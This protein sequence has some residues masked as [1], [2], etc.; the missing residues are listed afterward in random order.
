MACRPTL[1]HPIA[2]AV[3]L[4]LHGAA[5]AQ[6]VVTITGRSE[7]VADVS[8][9]GEKIS[10][11]PLQASVLDAASLRD[12]GI[13]SLAGITQADASVTDAYNAAGYWSLL[14]VRGF[15][16]D[17]RANYRRDGLPINAETALSLVN[18]ERVE[19]FKGT[20][21][22]QAGTSAPGGLVNLVVKRPLADRREVAL[23][24]T[25][26]GS[27]D[28]TLDLSQRLGTERR[29]GVRVNAEVATL[30]PAIRQAD[31]ER[32]LLAVAADWLVTPDA[33]LE[34]EI[35][36][37]HQ[38]QP[39]VPGFSLLGNR[40]PDARTIDPRTNLNN[41]PWSLPVVLDGDTASLRWQQRLSDDWSL[42]VHGASQRLRSDDRVAFPFGCSN[43]A[44]YLGDRYCADGSYDLYD[45]RSEGERRRTDALDLQVQGRAR[46]GSVQH[47]LTAGALLSRVHDRYQRVAN[48]YVGSGTINAD[49][50]TAADPSLTD[51]NT[52]RDERNREL[53]LRD[54]LQL[55]EQWQLWAGLRHS[56]IHRES[57]RTDG[58]RAIDYTQ[59]FTVPWLALGFTPAAGT[60]VYASW[61]QGVES[62]VVPNRAKYV[63]GG[64]ALPAL[65]SR[66]LE[67]GIKITAGATESSA[68]LFDIRR[69]V[70]SDRCVAA[71][72]CASEERFERRIDGV[73]RHRGLE[74]A[75]SLR[76]G[77]WTARAGALWLHARRE[78]SADPAL[79]GQRPTNV[80]DRSIKLQVG[81]DLGAGMSLQAELLH[82]GA[83][84]VLPDNSVMAGGWTRLDAA[85]D[86]RLPVTGME[87]RLRVAVDN[88]TDRRAW[89]E[90]PYQF[91]H[92]YLMPM[93]PR[94]WRVALNAS[95]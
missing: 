26:K 43:G 90:T 24:W 85:F 37:S 2:L 29:F 48:N 53:Y 34:F 55:S 91:G 35:E 5:A 93:P 66:Q 78:G 44:D 30:R 51:E 20:S 19:V 39:S 57:V 77:P 28:A 70:S 46:T 94:T 1:L 32:R 17:P 73:A 63:N 36:S 95:F 54:A 87:T 18:K 25:E 83:R 27:V 60:L 12:N 47:R 56:R 38:S 52:N 4:A 67:A 49:V 71:D 76:S 9:F 75:T 8:G 50:T 6:A 14:A 81:R 42:Q 65:K 16:I 64:Q 40:L 41:Q 92:V 33:R 61:G 79:N 23:G 89:R 69:P 82:E 13:V 74:L 84:A 15:V 88:L 22:I 86:W 11:A 7:A 62:E 3:L 80:P 10:R 59:G 45:F 31:G 21:G 68:T 58:S 72:G